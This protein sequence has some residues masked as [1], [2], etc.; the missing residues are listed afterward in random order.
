VSLSVSLPVLANANGQFPHARLRAMPLRDE[1]DTGIAASG[2]LLDVGVRPARGASA[3]A[4]TQILGREFRRRQ[5]DGGGVHAAPAVQVTRLRT[6][7]QDIGTGLPDSSDASGFEFETPRARS[8]L[9]VV[10]PGRNGDVGTRGVSQSLL[11]SLFVRRRWVSGQG[12][13]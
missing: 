7:A 5:R 10:R 8:R 1:R 6:S 11:A 3:A 9:Q 4:F 13:G 12:F 2:V